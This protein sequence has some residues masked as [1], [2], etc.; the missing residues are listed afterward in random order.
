MEC[1]SQVAW[2]TY[3]SL[4]FEVL[5]LVLYLYHNIG[6]SNHIKSPYVFSIHVSFLFT[7]LSCTLAMLSEPR[8]E[9]SQHHSD[10]ATSNSERVATDSFDADRVHEFPAPFLVRTKSRLEKESLHRQYQN[11]QQRMNS[12]Y[13][14][15]Q[16]LYEKLSFSAILENKSAVARDHLGKEI[17]CFQLGI[18]V[19]RLNVYN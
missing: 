14:W 19:F 7:S 3:I 9:F 5:T 15:I 8:T 18:S 6:D 17:V 1:R 4:D 12:P 11:Q 16:R 13:G 2:N 10:D